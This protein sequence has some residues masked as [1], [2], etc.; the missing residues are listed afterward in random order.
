MYQSTHKN[1]RYKY[2]KFQ[3]DFFYSLSNILINYCPEEKK[4]LHCPMG[5]EPQRRFKMGKVIFEQ[6]NKLKKN[7]EYDFFY[8]RVCTYL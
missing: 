8:F 5:V 7:C 6:W 1:F 2:M 3:R 4:I